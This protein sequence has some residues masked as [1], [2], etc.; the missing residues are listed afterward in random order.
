M[1]MVLFIVAS[2]YD[3]YVSDFFCGIGVMLT[4]HRSFLIKA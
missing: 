3:V 4:V 2:F 1:A